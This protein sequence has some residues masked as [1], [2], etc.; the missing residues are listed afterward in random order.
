VIDTGIMPYVVTVNTN[1]PTIM[2]GERGA[3]FVLETWK[4]YIIIKPNFY[5]YHKN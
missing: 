2:I 4:S 3:A 5:R 1:G